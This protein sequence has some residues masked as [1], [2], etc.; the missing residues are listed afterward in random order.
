MSTDNADARSHADWGIKNDLSMD[1][2]LSER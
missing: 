2:G 1:Y